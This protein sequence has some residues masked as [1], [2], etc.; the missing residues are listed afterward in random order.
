MGVGKNVTLDKAV[1]TMNV[2]AAGSVSASLSL[3]KR[4]HYQHSHFHNKFE[5]SC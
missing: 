4:G 1:G 5:A 2:C 3:F